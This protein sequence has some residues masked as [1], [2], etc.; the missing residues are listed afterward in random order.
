[1]DEL[2]G[3]ATGYAFVL[4]GF[5]RLETW[6]DLTPGGGGGAR[7]AAEAAEGVHTACA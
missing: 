5:A 2:A 4:H 6:I 3:T 1:M 7:T